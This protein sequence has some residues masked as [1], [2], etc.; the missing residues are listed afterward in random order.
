MGL[1]TH[2]FRFVVAF[3]C[4]LCLTSINSNYITMNF[5]FICM[6]SDMEGAIAD[7]NGTLHSRF[8]YT[9]SDK[10]FIVWAVAAGTILGTFPINWAY[11]NYGA[12]IP[13]FIAG[14]LSVIATAMI[15]LAASASFYFL[16][17][18]RFVQGLAYS[19]DFAAIGL[20]TICDSSL[21]WRWAFYS[22]AFVC[23]IF[24]IAWIFY[25][26]DNPATHKAVDTEELKKIQK[27]KT[28]AHL[29]GDSYVPYWSICQNRTIM[30]VWFNSFA[31]MTTVTLLLTY[32]PLYFHKA[33]CT[34]PTMLV[35]WF[36]S[37]TEM[38]TGI[39]LLTYMPLYFHKVLGFDVVTTGILA[40]VTSFMHAPLKYL[41]GYCS[42]K[43]TSIPE[44]IKMQFCNFIA[45]GFAGICCIV[46]GIVKT[47]GGGVVA[48]CFFAGVYLAMAANCGGF[49]KCGTLVSRQYAHFVLAT[50][51]F[52]KCVA[53]VAA[54]ASWAIFVRNESDATEWSY[55]FYLNGAVLILANIMFVFVCTDQPA[56]F[57]Y[58]TRDNPEGKHRVAPAKIAN[59]QADQ[60]TSESALTAEKLKV[61]E[62]P[63]SQKESQK[64]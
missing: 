22:H 50:I 63:E 60:K 26:T 35:V 48:V 14:T 55:V 8:K 56:D 4:F 43:I 32:M 54:P 6:E 12:R 23:A 57:T 16:L 25:Y 20:V 41:S 24:F 46:I 3:G 18:L 21:G 34:N 7:E 52:M 49:Y 64:A 9:P 11:I 15:P 58:I 42:D 30:V 1:L 36:N 28:Q 31:E 39:L 17:S 51:Q 45:V 2:R 29:D 5:T 38:T 62:E 19:A 13:F 44:G 27:D 59:G 37:L 61:D 33:I 40:A 53:L 10:N 47:S